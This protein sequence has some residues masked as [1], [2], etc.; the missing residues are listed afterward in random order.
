VGF[1]FFSPKL[2]PEAIYDLMQARI[3]PGERAESAPLVETKRSYKT[4]AAE[5]LLPV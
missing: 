1:F 3:P 2:G 5:L 4:S